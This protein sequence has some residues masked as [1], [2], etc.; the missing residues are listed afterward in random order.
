MSHF[1][2]TP[3]MTYGL[4]RSVH[5]H[6]GPRIK[7]TN[8]AITQ[9]TENPT[10]PVCAATLKKYNQCVF[11]RGFRIL[12]KKAQARRRLGLKVKGNSG[13]LQELQEP[14]FHKTSS[15]E[16]S[17]TSSVN[18]GSSVTDGGGSGR[19]RA[20]FIGS[21]TRSDASD[22]EI[23]TNDIH[24][25]APVES[26]LEHILDVRPHSVSV[27]PH[28]LMSLVWVDHRIPMP[29]LRLPMTMIWVFL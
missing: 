20:R 12:D 15:S 7:R 1:S 21:P 14:W 10:P 18:R 16:C 5:S 17:D 9:A 25:H 22:I 19:Q 4:I 13:G 29:K 11:L 26:L 6:C 2:S 23:V 24:V 28:A 3:I 8:P 27:P